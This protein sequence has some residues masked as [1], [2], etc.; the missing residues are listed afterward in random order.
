MGACS[1]WPEN[2]NEPIKGARGLIG[3]K[4][5]AIVSGSIRPEDEAWPLKTPDA[6]NKANVEAQAIAKGKIR[7][8]R[9]ETAMSRAKIK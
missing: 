4:K 1:R 3:L 7:K 2:I 5:E 6:M 9:R 8:P